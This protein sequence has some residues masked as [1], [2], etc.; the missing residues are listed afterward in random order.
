VFGSLT[1]ARFVD[2]NGEHLLAEP[3]PTSLTNMC[4]IQ[5]TTTSTSCTG[6][7]EG[8]TFA[9]RGGNCDDTNNLQEGKLTCDDVVEGVGP[10]TT[11]SVTIVVSGSGKDAGKVYGTFD[12]VDLDE[13]VTALA[14]MGGKNTLGAESIATIYS[15]NGTLL[16]TIVFHTSCSKPLSLGDRFGALEVVA[17]SLEDGSTISQESTGNLVEYQYVITNNNESGGTIVTVESVIDDMIGSIYPIPPDFDDLPFPL[18][19]GESST[20]FRTVNVTETT[21]NTV[22]VTSDCAAPVEATATVTVTEALPP[23]ADSCLD[24]KPHQLVFE[25]TGKSCALTENNNTQGDKFSCSEPGN[26]LNGEFSVQIELALSGKDVDKTTVSPTT[27][28]VTISDVDNTNEVTFTATGSRLPA[29][30]TFN[31]LQDGVIL[32]SLDVHTSC[33]APLAVG[34]EFGGMR[35]KK[36]IAEP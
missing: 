13:S 9:Y 27:Q 1:I 6:K 36:F 17:M 29:H 12:N 23:T 34:N 20:F 28:V 30:T 35:L 10:G 4:S 15:D 19:P 22:T 14:S 16:E 26:E 18:N 3:E 8:L 5:T 7:L 32:Q 31:I 2:I 24:G 11:E 21:M 25:Y 33:S